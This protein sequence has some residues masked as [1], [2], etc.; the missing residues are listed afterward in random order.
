MVVAEKRILQVLILLVVGIYIVVDDAV[1]YFI[2]GWLKKTN[3][4]IRIIGNIPFVE[5]RQCRCY[6]LNVIYLKK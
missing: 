4:I 5:E 2:I 1:K 3:S 6:F